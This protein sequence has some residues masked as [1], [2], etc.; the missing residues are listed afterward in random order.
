MEKFPD[1]GPV[2]TAN[3]LRESVLTVTFVTCQQSN[4]RE[5]REEEEGGGRKRKEEGKKIYGVFSSCG[6]SFTSK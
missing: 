1:L 6:S 4:E 5:E 2:F 3:L